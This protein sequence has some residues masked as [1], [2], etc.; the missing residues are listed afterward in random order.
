[1]CILGLSKVLMQEFH[2]D[3]ENK[4]GN[5]SRPLFKCTDSLMYDIKAEDIYED[6]SKDEE[7]LDFINY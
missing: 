4:Y 2:Y 1:M 5:I 7:M 3:I 6:F